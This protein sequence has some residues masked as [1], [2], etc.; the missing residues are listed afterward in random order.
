LRHALKTG[1]VLSTLEDMENVQLPASLVETSKRTLFT[2]PV[3]EMKDLREKYK[4]DK[5]SV[6]KLVGIKKMHQAISGG[7]G[8][9]MVRRL[10]CLCALLVLIH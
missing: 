2:F 5:L 1:D 7:D 8:T 6:P 10:S 3:N 4:M 9:I